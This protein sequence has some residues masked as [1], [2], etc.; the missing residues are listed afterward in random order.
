MIWGAS[1]FFTLMATQEFGPWS[2]AWMRVSVAA[3]TLLPL[4]FW[5]HQAQTIKAEWRALFGMGLFNSAVPFF[6][7]AFALQ[8]LSTGLSSILN[9]TTPLFGALIA[10]LWLKDRPT[11]W[12]GLGLLLG[13]AGSAWLAV[14]APGGVSF[15]TGGSGWAILA[16]L[17]ATCCYSFSSLYSQRHLQ[18]VSPMVIATGSQLGAFVVLAVPG[19]WYWPSV[20]PSMNAWLSLLA[21]GMMSTGLAYV[22]YFRLIVK[23]GA[24]RT[25]TLTY[26]IPLFANLIGVFVLDEIVTGSMLMA[27]GV[28]LL[29]TAMASGLFPRQAV[30]APP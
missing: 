9:A 24:A 30:S 25:M 4:V 5:Q 14:H 27:G 17:L 12:R 21:V 19:Y 1:F 20:L 22:L 28:I 15:K 29:G 10:W 8:S 6:C 18:H 23:T 26:L 2:T 16:C 3:I 7:F 13:F 11:H